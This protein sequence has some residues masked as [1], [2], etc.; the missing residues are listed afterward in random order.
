VGSN[1]TL[2]AGATGGAYSVLTASNLLVP[3]N[4]WTPLITNQFGTQGRSIFTSV[5]S[6]NTPQR[7][8]ILQIQP[9]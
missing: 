1:L 4:Q 6:A 7:F 5:A 9:P 2:V 8:N 3:L